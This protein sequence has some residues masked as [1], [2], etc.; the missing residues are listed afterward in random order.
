[1]VSVDEIPSS[2]SGKSICDGMAIKY[3]AEK[4]SVRNS[5]RNG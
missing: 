2:Y 1:M 5:V 3:F 4:I